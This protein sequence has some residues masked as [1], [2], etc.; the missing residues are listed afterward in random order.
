MKLRSKEIQWY[1]LVGNLNKNKLNQF[2]EEEASETA[3]FLNEYAQNDFLFY[4]IPTIYLLM[5]EKN[6]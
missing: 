6:D 2:Y 5:E 4:G 1:D 3:Y